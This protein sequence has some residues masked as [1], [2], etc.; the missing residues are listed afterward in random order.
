MLAGVMGA[1][2]SSCSGHR[3]LEKSR[4]SPS[5]HLSHARQLTLFRAGAQARGGGRRG[6]TAWR[7]AAILSLTTFRAPGPGPRHPCCS[8]CHDSRRV[9]ARGL[10]HRCLS[11]CRPGALT[12]HHGRA[13]R[14]RTPG[15][16]ALWLDRGADKVF[17]RIETEW[18]G[19]PTSPPSSRACA[20][21]GVS[22]AFS[23]KF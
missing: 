21:R 22:S 10:Q 15:R 19:S 14:M 12:R 2:G 23:G 17:L 18:T 9:G 16:R 11:P 7:C 13:P 20:S 8:R 4:S 6:E 1:R 3:S 5:D